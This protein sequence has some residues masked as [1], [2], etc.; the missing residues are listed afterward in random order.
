MSQENVRPQPN[1]RELGSRDVR[2]LPSGALAGE[3]E[4]VAE[5]ARAPHRGVEHFPPP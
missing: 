3:R 2:A 1:D 5:C 4:G